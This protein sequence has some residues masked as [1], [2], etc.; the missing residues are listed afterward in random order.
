MGLDQIIQYESMLRTGA[1]AMLLCSSLGI[2]GEGKVTLSEMDRFSKDNCW[3]DSNMGNVNPCPQE[4]EGAEGADRYYVCMSLYN[5]LFV[6]VVIKY[7]RRLLRVFW[8]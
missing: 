4:G 8:I 1:W 7:V 3:D 2:P 6:C 5:M